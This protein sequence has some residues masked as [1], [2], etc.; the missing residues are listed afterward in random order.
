MPIIQINGVSVDFPKDPYNCQVEYMGKVI[1]ALSA[2]ENALLESP[3]GTGKTLS[4]LCSSLAW[5][6]AHAASAQAAPASSQSS[7][8]AAG[9][10]PSSDRNGVI[11]YATRT[12]SQLS[13]VIR[14]L[15]DTSYRPKMAV[16]G[17]RDQLCIHDKV[18]K[19][20]TAS[21]NHA[22]QVAV[23]RHT[24]QFKNNLE[25]MIDGGSAF[26]ASNEVTDIEDLVKM[27]R[28]RVVCP[29]YYS[30][31]S[32]ATAD[33]VFMPYNYLLDGAIRKTIKINL[34]NSIVIF[35][36]A[37]NLEQVA[38]DAAS[39]SFSS[40]DLAACIQEMQQILEILKAEH[41]RKADSGSSLNKASKTE[42]GVERPSLPASV[43]VLR[44]LFELEKIFDRVV[45]TH[46]ADTD[47]SC[48]IHP[49]SW[50]VNALIHAGFNSDSVCF[51]L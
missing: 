14:E 42:S 13:Q 11:V 29:Y 41:S 5:Q 20:K 44:A 12:H 46:N 48:A 24:C 4:L 25:S 28:R 1:Q 51:P 36:E 39:C 19:L 3:T 45:L 7:N 49:G 33:I 38:S 16:L 32:S 34:Q 26:V 35:D 23:S 37:H 27:G 6:S 18:S 8:H 21:L 47:T 15:R 31:D 9:S 40:A 30:R 10:Q 43:A 2:G 50:L 22:C 17:S